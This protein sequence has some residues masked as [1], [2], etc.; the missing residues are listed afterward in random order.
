MENRKVRRNRKLN[1]KKIGLLLA[2]LVIILLIIFFVSKKD[3]NINETPKQDLS[4]VFY[5]DNISK[6]YDDIISIYGQGTDNYNMDN[7]IFATVYTDKILDYNSTNI[8]YYDDD[9]KV[10]YIEYILGDNSIYEVLNKLKEILGDTFEYNNDTEELSTQFTWKYENYLIVLGNNV[11][12]ISII[13]K[14]NI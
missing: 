14:P 5:F 10:K 13:V 4:Q 7:K 9:M 11:S 1:K 12:N 8:F 6:T 3:N 2:I